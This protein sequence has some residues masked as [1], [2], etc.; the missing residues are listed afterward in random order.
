LRL[1]E[2][3]LCFALSGTLEEGND[4]PVFNRGFRGPELSRNVDCPVPD[5]F[6][7]P[8]LEVLLDRGNVPTEIEAAEVS[9]LK[10]EYEDMPVTIPFQSEEL[11]G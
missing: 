5:I 10:V 8:M 3:H 9:V 6:Q 7:A 2:R 11:A 1:L 4:P